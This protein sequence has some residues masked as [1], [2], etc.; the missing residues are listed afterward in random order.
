MSFIV[1]EMFSSVLNMVRI[2]AS[3]ILGLVKILL[4][5]KHFSY[6]LFQ[7]SRIMCIKV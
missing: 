5:S 7:Y 4:F 2:Y 6:R 1:G 3:G